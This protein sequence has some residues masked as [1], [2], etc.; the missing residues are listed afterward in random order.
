MSD[1]MDVHETAAFLRI[2]P[3][4]VYRWR[5]DLG[6]PGLL[7][8]RRSLRFSRQAVLEWARDRAPEDPLVKDVS[9]R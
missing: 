4:T 3:I 5:K 2:H 6:L 1:L 7:L 8:S 9:A